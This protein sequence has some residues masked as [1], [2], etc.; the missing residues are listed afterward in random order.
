MG[1]AVL[2]LQCSLC[3]DGG[4]GA[5][6]DVQIS[7]ASQTLCYHAEAAAGRGCRCSDCCG[8]WGPVARPPAMP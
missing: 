4:L 7:D 1:R 2:M 3:A 5:G 6:K 8:Y